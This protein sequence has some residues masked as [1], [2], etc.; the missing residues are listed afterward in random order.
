MLNNARYRSN[1]NET[2]LVIYN[3]IPSNE[4][5]VNLQGDSTK[6]AVAMNIVNFIVA[7]PVPNIRYGTQL[8]APTTDGT[9]TLKVTVT[10]GK[11]TFS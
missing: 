10:S 8:N 9:Y 5:D 11:P 7:N 2:G 6:N 1:L 4:G 3:I